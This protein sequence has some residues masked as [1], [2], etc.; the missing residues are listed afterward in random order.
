M[1]EVSE[2]LSKSEAEYK[3]QLIWN[4]QRT[5][6]AAAMPS[7]YKDAAIHALQ[8]RF[9]QTV[10]RYI[11]ALSTW[12]VK[13]DAT[14]E[15][16]MLKQIYLLASGPNSLTFPPGIRGC[17]VQ[18]VQQSYAAERQRVAHQLCRDAA[19][20]LRELK[21]KSKQVPQVVNTN[22]THVYNMP[23]GRVYNNSVDQSTNY[24]EFTLPD[25]EAIDRISEGHVQLQEVA[26]ELRAAYPQRATMLEKAQKWA[27][28]LSSV[29][30]M[31]EKVHQYYPQVEVFLRH[32]TK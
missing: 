3:S 26:K 22:V 19:N 7:A 18:A 28:L 9:E 24:F 31:M 20:R 13:I 12:G 5:N 1:V 4:A 16:E 2:R 15:K 14:V 10:E 6:N 25:L 21:M 32:L 23:N 11:E 17:H 30:G 8:T 27:V 29:E